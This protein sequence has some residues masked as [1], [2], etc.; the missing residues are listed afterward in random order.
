MKIT[1][2][3]L[4]GTGVI[5][6]TGG[7]TLLTGNY[8]VNC[9]TLGSGVGLIVT[10]SGGDISLDPASVLSLDNLTKEDKGKKFTI[11]SGSITGGWAGLP[12][13]T[14]SVKDNTNIIGDGLKKFNIT[15]SGDAF[16]IEILSMGADFVPYNSD[17]GI[18]T[19]I[20]NV[21]TLMG[22]SMDP[23]VGGFI[24]AISDLE[25]SFGAK[26]ASNSIEAVAAM[27][28]AGGT[29]HSTTTLMDHFRDT[30]FDH[31]SIN[32]RPTLKIVK[33]V[34]VRNVDTVGFN[35]VVPTAV[36]VGNV[37][38]IMPE[39]RFDTEER[40]AKQVWATHIRNV[41]KVNGLELGGVTSRQDSRINGAMMGADL[42][43]SNHSFGGFAIMYAN[44]S[45]SGS[46]G[47]V[48]TSNKIDYYGAGFY[49]R[50]DLGANS[51][52]LY[53]LSYIYSRNDIT[54][55]NTGYEISAEPVVNSLSAGFRYEKMF[56]DLSNYITTYFGA[57]YQHIGGRQYENNLNNIR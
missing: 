17:D 53:D 20:Y 39:A 34:R 38:E 11:Y 43:S 30:L 35:D 3:H 42:W 31:I 27:G 15:N 22:E 28:E 9:A 18:E 40:Y 2:G 44:G 55:S 23:K 10:N 56:G 45:V 36:E 21:A 5:N 37:N 1:G 49:N 41:E 4:D 12:S 33:K 19:S 48:S 57:R 6:V 26:E 24:D 51:D 50:S 52:I 13:G 54:Q 29:L 7:E 14:Y 46:I 8:Y 25:T 16:V 47:N 32:E